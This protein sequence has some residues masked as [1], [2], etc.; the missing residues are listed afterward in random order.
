ME[1]ETVTKETGI[2][3]LFVVSLY[4]SF[5]KDDFMSNNLSI[6]NKLE[7]VMLDTVSQF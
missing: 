2:D 6:I 4:G 5:V 3:E 7:N 1:S